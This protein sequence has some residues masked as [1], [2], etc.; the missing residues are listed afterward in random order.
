MI[1]QKFY[2]CIKPLDLNWIKLPIHT[3]IKFKVKSTIRYHS[4]YEVLTNNNTRYK[5]VTNDWDNPL[6]SDFDI[7]EHFKLIKPTKKMKLLYL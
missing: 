1:K 4:R 2:I 3:I 5:E 6:L 7:H